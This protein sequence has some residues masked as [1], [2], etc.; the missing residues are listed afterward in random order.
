MLRVDRNVQNISRQ[1]LLVLQKLTALG[2][3]VKLGEYES[4]ISPRT[5]TLECQHVP[6]VSDP[7]HYYTLLALSFL[8]GAGKVEGGVEGLVEI[9]RRQKGLSMPAVLLRFAGAEVPEYMDFDAVSRELSGLSDRTLLRIGW[10]LRDETVK[11]QMGEQA[12]TVKA[13][14]ER[15]RV[16]IDPH[17]L[18]LY[19]KMKNF[20]VM[21]VRMAGGVAVSRFGKAWPTDVLV[22]DG[23]GHQ[24]DG[25]FYATGALNVDDIVEQGNGLI[26]KL[27]ASRS[28]EVSY[29][30][31][32]IRYVQVTTASD[33]AIKMPNS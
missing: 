20:R 15:S 3:S 2:A 13:M 12:K 24:R 25:Y 10:F 7:G 26:L 14:I 16:T 8:E 27:S 1:A 31:E 9:A 17:T 19:S 4:T 29:L 30:P 23:F 22:R 6:H 28:Y 18:S 32:E 5:R 33:P 21:G 11:S